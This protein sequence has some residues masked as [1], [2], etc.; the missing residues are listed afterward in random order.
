LKKEKV[1]NKKE[2]CAVEIAWKIFVMSG[3]LAMSFLLAGCASGNS[4]Q[5]VSGIL[6]GIGQGLS[7]L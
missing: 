4:G 1:Q 3:V 2:V 5:V 6:Q 7:G